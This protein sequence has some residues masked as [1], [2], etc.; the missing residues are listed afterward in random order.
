MIASSSRFE[1]FDRAAVA[2]ITASEPF[3]PLPDQFTGEEIRVQF[4]FLYKFVGAEAWAD[5]LAAGRS[6]LDDGTLHVARFDDDG[7]GR[8]LPLVAGRG[9]LLGANG[10]ADDGD[11]LVKTRLAADLLGATPMDRPEWTMADERTGDVFVTLTNNTERDPTGTGAANPRGPNP[12]GHILRWNE[13]GDPAADTFR[14]EVFLLGGEETGFGS[15][16]GLWLD[17]HGVLWIATDGPQPE[18]QEPGPQDRTVNGECFA[19]DANP[20]V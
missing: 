4:D 2:A 14:W 18:G 7:T 5:A 8:W 6:P 12:F 15:P 17:P 19:D 20:P 16:D 11:V 13:G 3:P 10:F 9:P 1:P